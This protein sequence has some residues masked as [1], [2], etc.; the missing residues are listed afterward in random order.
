MLLYYFIV[1]ITTKEHEVVHLGPARERLLREAPSWFPCEVFCGGDN[2]AMR[3]AIHVHTPAPKKFH[4]I[5]AVPICSTHV[6]Y[7]LSRAWAWV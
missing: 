2:S 7:K 6:F 4:R 5:P 3:C 1:I